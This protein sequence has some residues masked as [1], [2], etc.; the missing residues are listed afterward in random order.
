MKYPLDVNCILAYDTS[1]ELMLT[2][3]IA[4]VENDEVHEVTCNLM[5]IFNV[6]MCNDFSQH[7]FKK[8]FDANGRQTIS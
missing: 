3:V 8:W 4:H 7:R 6:Y 2:R 1:L 5:D